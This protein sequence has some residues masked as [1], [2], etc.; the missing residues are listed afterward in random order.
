VNWSALEI[1][2]LGGD[3]RECEIARLAAATGAAVRA[4]GLPWP[5]GGIAGVTLEPDADAAMAG[6]RYALFPVPGLGVD[7]SLYAP[8]A[9]T[10]VLPDER[11]LGL[12]A[13]GGHVI[14]GSADD[15]LRT[16]ASAAGVELHE[17]EGDPELMLLRVP[18]IVEGAIQIAIEQTPVT[19]HASDV[20]VV[21]HG[22]TGSA[23][24]RTLISIG[25]RV[26]VFARNPVQRAAAY[27]AG[28][29]PH[30]LDELQRPTP[31]LAVLFS[32]VPAR[33]VGPEVLSELSPDA[34]VIDLAAPP[35]SVDLAAAGRLGRKAIWARGLGKRAPVTV[36]QSQWLGIRKTI[37]AIEEDR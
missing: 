11:L 24:V 21:G 26:H 29:V 20:G 18:A 36:G 23:L 14:L 6:A 16:A 37:E 13:P 3:E 9:S 4:W 32:T 10:P 1:A 19:I 8:S 22:K 5:R 35:G 2:M 27:V 28:A 25:A 30:T 17:Y 12:L 34:I 15:R 33:V 7:G 31:N